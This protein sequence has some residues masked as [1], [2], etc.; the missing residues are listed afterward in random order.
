M[1]VM[2]RPSAAVPRRE[3]AHGHGPLSR[4]RPSSQGGSVRR[5]GSR[6]QRASML[7]TSQTR[8]FVAITASCSRARTLRKGCSTV[9]RASGRRWFSGRSPTEQPGRGATPSGRSLAGRVGASPSGKA[10]DFDSAMRRFESC[11][12]SQYPLHR[13]VQFLLPSLRVIDIA[14]AP[15]QPCPTSQHSRPVASSWGA[16]GC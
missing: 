9:D 13:S 1:Q 2:P 12:P 14:S 8:C 5:C 10:A 15:R 6:A 4:S 16:E 7:G 11:R 3:R